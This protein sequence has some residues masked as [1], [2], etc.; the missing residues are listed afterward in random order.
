[1]NGPDAAGQR[2]LMLAL[3][4]AQFLHTNAAGL[5]D[6][7]RREGHAYAWS[8]A[9]QARDA[10]ADLVQQIADDAGV[11][12]QGTGVIPGEVVPRPGDTP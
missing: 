10:L 12:L 8:C 5:A 11:P 1:M 2:R 9:M 6:E 4:K 7:L 3:G